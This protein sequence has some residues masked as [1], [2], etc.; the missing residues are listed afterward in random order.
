[1][2]NIVRDKVIH[3]LVPNANQNIL[4]LREMDKFMVDRFIERI[5]TGGDKKED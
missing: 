5:I 2:V 1:M 4:M 3:G